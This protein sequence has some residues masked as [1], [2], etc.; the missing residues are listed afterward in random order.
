MR[1]RT[2]AKLHMEQKEPGREEMEAAIAAM[3]KALDKLSANVEKLRPFFEPDHEEDINH[4][5]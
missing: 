1:R 5:E 3:M 4:G 2:S